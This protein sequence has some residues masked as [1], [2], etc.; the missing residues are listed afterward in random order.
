MPVKIAQN[1]YIPTLHFDN[2]SFNMYTL[3]TDRVS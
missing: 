3:K 2:N 1:P